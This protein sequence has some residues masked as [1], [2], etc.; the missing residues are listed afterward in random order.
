[1]R[2]D[3]HLHSNAS[4]GECPPDEVV[5]RALDANLDVISLTDHD[6]VG[7]VNDAREAATGSPIHVIPGLEVSSTWEGH[8]IHVLGYFVD[9][10]SPALR[11]YAEHARRRRIERMREMLLLLED[12]G[13]EVPFEEVLDAAGE[14]VESL[15]RPHLA[16]AL[17]EAGHVQNVPEAFMRYIGDDGPA[18]VPTRVQDPS[19]AVELIREADGL[20]SWAHPPR[21]Q[22]DGLLPVLVEAGLEGLEIYRPNHLPRQ[23]E[24]LKGRARRYDLVVTGGSDWHGPDR[25]RNLGDFYVSSEEV[26][27]FLDR[28]GI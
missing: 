17:V 26:E 9:V 25:G 12:I 5:R 6:T 4:D 21:D 13:I 23:V 7:G 15:A 22:L 28:G 14:E 19:R 20:A 18:F 3:L 27:A 1:M 2:L 8:D 10:E 11:D 24:D 16:E